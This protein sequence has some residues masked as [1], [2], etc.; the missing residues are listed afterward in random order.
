ARRI[1]VD[2]A[3]HHRT[4]DP[5]LPELHRTLTDL[6]PMTPTIP[7]I[8]TTTHPTTTT[9]T[10]NADHW[11]ANLR[12]PVH[13]HHAITTASTHHA[14]FIEISP[15]PLL[16]HAITETVGAA[17]HHSIGTLQRDTHD[18]LI[19]HTNLNA[20]LT[21]HPPNTEHVTGPHPVLRP[22]PWHH[23]RHWITVNKRAD[24]AA[25]APLSGTLLGKHIAL[26]T[27]PPTHLWQAR[28]VPEAKP[29][30]GCH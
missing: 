5:I 19:F 9:P 7:L 12:N 26:A 13:F 30:P 28:L 8:S 23:T 11:I 2:V 10:F 24:V 27:T 22:T 25:P 4:V 15:H 29:Y 14:T 16:T 17:H 1:D 20:T 6:T 18:T 3:S 21:D